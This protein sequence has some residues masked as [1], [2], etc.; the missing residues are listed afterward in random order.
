[1]EGDLRNSCIVGTG[2]KYEMEVIGNGFLLDILCS[3]F[4]SILGKGHEKFLKDII[5]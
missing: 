2:L 1:M 3:G 4:S 5:K